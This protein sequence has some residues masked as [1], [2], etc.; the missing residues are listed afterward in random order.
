MEIPEVDV[1]RWGLPPDRKIG[2]VRNRSGFLFLPRGVFS[3]HGTRWLE[4]GS[5]R[6]VWTDALPE[7]YWRFDG[8]EN[9]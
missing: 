2:E 6:E 5:W 3:S 8:W 1:V 4:W 9:S 7:A